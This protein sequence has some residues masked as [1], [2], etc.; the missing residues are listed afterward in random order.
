MSGTK[1]PL[2][3][4]VVN[5]LATVVTIIIN[6][7]ASVLPLHGETTAQLSDDIPNYF[8]PAGWVF[9]IWG[10]IYVFMAIFAIYQLMPAHREDSFIKK[11]GPL[12]LISCIA[13]ST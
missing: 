4:P 2:L 7:I 6:A 12:Y 13:N 8:V 11:V 5:L 9:S 10:A 1:S 3:W